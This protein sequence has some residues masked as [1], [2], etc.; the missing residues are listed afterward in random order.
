MNGKLLLIGFITLISCS[1]DANLINEKI[2]EKQYLETS[3]YV[4]SDGVIYI[5]DTVYYNS[6]GSVSSLTGDVS[7]RN[8]FHYDS[9]NYKIE[10]VD[11]EPYE[12]AFYMYEVII[13]EHGNP[14]TATF[15]KNTNILLT[16]DSV[17]FE[18]DSN[19]KLIRQNNFGLNPPYSPGYTGY[20]LMEYPDES[21]VV[22]KYFNH[23]GK[24]LKT[25]TLTYDNNPVPSLELAWRN[26]FF[27]RF[28]GFI[29]RGH[30]IIRGKTFNHEDST[31]LEWNNEIKYNEAGYPVLVNGRDVYT[32]TA[33]PNNY[34]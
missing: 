5:R 13:N 25:E 20:T 6:D 11:R 3:G 24:P 22:E 34:K 19:N 10:I 16:W 30:N 29:P 31:T 4:G 9:A 7:S 12:E 2:F 17:S 15:Y 14:V 23:E 28:D 8:Y 1:D 33:T 27:S 26:F 18:Y 21:T 32:Y